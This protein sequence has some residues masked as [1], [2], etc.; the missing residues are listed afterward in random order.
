MSEAFATFLDY[1]PLILQGSRV[2][3]QVTLFSLSLSCVLGMLAALG[4]LSPNPVFHAPLHL[5]TTVVRGVP[6]LILML[7][8]YYGGQIALNHLL[9]AVGYEEFVEIDAFTAG[10]VTIGFIFGAYMCETFRGAVLSIRQ[11]EIEAARAFGMNGRQ[12]FRR[13]VFPQ[14]VVYALPSFFNNC[15]VLIKTTALISVIGLDD[16][17][18]K[19]KMAGDT[20]RMPF[21][22][23]FAAALVYLAISSVLILATRRLEKKYPQIRRAS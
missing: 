11:G 6:D 2:T 13:I 9:E 4:K 15:Q 20:T 1:L 7:L 10:G 23:L 8:I 5:Y 17:V 18:R 14:M 22:F 3:I 12:T 16:V 19:S 21:T